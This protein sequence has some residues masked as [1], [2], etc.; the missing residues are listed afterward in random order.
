MARGSQHCS[1]GEACIYRQINVYSGNICLFELLKEIFCLKYLGGLW[2]VNYQRFLAWIE[3]VCKCASL[4]TA[5]AEAQAVHINLFWL[6]FFRAVWKLA[7]RCMSI[8]WEGLKMNTS[9]K[10]RQV[11]IVL[12]VSYRLY[13]TW[14]EIQKGKKLDTFIKR[15]WANRLCVDISLSKKTEKSVGRKWCIKLVEINSVLI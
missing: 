9:P 12:Y 7:V 5:V 10:Q 6:C 13:Q 4:L 2:R 14:F 15:W 11:K 1:H 8:I 3:H